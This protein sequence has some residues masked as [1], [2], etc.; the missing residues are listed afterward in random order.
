MV[1]VKNETPQ[2]VL[3]RVGVDA[4]EG[5]IQGPLLDEDGTFDYLPIPDTWSR[6]NKI[7]YGNTLGRHKRFLNEYWTGKKKEFYRTHPIHFDP[8]FKT[9]TYGDPTRPKQSLRWL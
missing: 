7:L 1:D 4:G 2:V 9:F 6:Q 3:L 5:G 8:E